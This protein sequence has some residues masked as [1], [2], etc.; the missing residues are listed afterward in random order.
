MVGT[1]TVLDLFDLIGVEPHPLLCTVDV[2][3]FSLRDRQLRFGN[4]EAYLLGG[5]AL[6]TLGGEDLRVTFGAH[7]GD[8]RSVMVTVKCGTHPGS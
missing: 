1:E 8:P 5:K 7:S 2:A 4:L 3:T 6:A